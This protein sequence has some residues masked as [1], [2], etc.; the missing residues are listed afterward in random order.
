[1]TTIRPHTSRTVYHNRFL[2]DL[3]RCSIFDFSDQKIISDES[4]I[5]NGHY[6]FIDTQGINILE[7]V[8]LTKNLPSPFE[9]AKNIADLTAKVNYLETLNQKSF[10]RFYVW[11]SGVIAA[12][13]HLPFIFNETVYNDG[14]MYDINSGQV[15]I[16]FN[17]MYIFT[18]SFYKWSIS[19]NIAFTL[20]INGEHHLKSTTLVHITSLEQSIFENLK[21]NR[22]LMR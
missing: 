2:G 4:V 14:S 21:K 17:G 13:Q 22:D 15:T 10:P 6:E 19:E 11:K 9:M 18:V 3:A 16:P 12:E 1:M 7:P 8:S 20:S 5:N